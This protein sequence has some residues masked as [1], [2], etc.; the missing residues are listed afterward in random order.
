VGEPIGWRKISENF[1][2][3]IFAVQIYFFDRFLVFHRD[4]LTSGLRI[5]VASQSRR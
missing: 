2:L 1:M 5:K 3:L 4:R